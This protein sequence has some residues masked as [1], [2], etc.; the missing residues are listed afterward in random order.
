MT[1]PLPVKTA[2]P[3]PK[4]PLDTVKKTAQLALREK[5]KLIEYG[6][7]EL[8]GQHWDSAEKDELR[9]NSV[10]RIFEAGVPQYEGWKI[11]EGVYITLTPELVQRAAMAFMQHYGKAFQVE[12]AKLAEIETLKSVEAVDAWLETELNQGW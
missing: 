7:F 2:N 11:S 3:A 6:G 4:P 5:R 10:T 8:D 9:L 12:A 1:I